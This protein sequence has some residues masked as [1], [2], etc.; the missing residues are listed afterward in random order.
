LPMNKA[1]ALEIHLGRLDRVDGLSS[2]PWEGSFMFLWNS[3][4]SLTK[5]CA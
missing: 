5:K 4:L 1:M 3:P 2:P